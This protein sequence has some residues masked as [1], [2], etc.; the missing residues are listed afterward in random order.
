MNPSATEILTNPHPKG[1][2]VYPYTDEAHVAEAVSLFAAAGL[3]KGEAV[4]LIMTASHCGPILERLGQEGFDLS[5]LK[6]SGQLVCEDAADLMSTF[7][8][9]GI[10][11]EQKFKATLN[12]MIVKAKVGPLGRTR[13]VR[14]FGEMVDLLWRN[15]P[16]TTLRLEQLWNEVIER[17]S[18]PLLCAY[19]LAGTIADNFPEALRGC[20]SH[21]VTQEIEAASR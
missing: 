13:R 15:D 11:D 19:S 20:H 2:I 17:Q 1:H 3:H 16:H 9:D 4:L 5:E 21:D 7:I 8:F 14:V 18:V 10:V 12:D 6:A